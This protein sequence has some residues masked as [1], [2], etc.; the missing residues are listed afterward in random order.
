MK[1]TYGPHQ[2]PEAGSANPQPNIPD[3]ESKDHPIMGMTCIPL[4]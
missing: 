2:M 4:A 3:I 1:Q